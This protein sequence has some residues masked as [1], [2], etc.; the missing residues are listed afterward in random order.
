MAE[1]GDEPVCDEAREA[2][3]KEAEAVEELPEDE[4]EEGA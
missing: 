4:S 2:M 1:P 3:R